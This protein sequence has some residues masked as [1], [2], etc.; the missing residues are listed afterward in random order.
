M[1]ID[2]GVIAVR[3]LDSSIRVF[4]EVLGLDARRGGRHGG[5][6]T[7]NAIVRFPDSYLELLSLHDAEKE[8]AVSGLRGQ[9]LADFIRRREGGAVGFALSTEELVSHS[10]RL[11]SAGLDVPEPLSVSRSL[12]SGGILRWKVMLPGKVNWRRP[13]PFLIQ[14]DPENA[15]YRAEEPPGEHPLGAT[16]VAGVAIAM[17]DLARGRDLY[18]RQFAFREAGEDL[19]PELAARRVR[20]ELE[21]F[22]IDVLAPAGGGAL[23]AELDSASEGTFQFLLRVS[24]LGAASGWLARSG[25]ELQTAPGYPGARLIPPDRAAGARFALTS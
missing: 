19:V 25:V 20:F 17:E 12:P 23:R 1:R 13:W 16:G 4:R 2:H 8:I 18:G 21:N 6:G 3:D 5:R 24:D 11:R 15:R 10:Q 14:P 9:I 22:G 7:E